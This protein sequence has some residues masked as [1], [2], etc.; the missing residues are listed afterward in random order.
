MGKT[1][2]SED[3]VRNLTLVDISNALSGGSKGELGVFDT[4]LSGL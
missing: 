2:N 1:P 3:F 4:L